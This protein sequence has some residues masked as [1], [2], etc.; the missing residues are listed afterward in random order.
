MTVAEATLRVT[1]LPAGSTRPFN[2]VTMSE[3]GGGFAGSGATTMAR[4]V[5]V[6]CRPCLSTAVAESW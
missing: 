1:R 6:F 5:E 3:V 2:G 4:R